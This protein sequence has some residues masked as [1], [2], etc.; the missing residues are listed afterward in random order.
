M[1]CDTCVE[2]DVCVSCVDDSKYC[3]DCDRDEIREWLR[4]W[5]GIADDDDALCELCERYSVWEK[6]ICEGCEP[7]EYCEKKPL[8]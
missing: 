3:D 6:V 7:T 4:K 8:F 1:W 2:C 5:K